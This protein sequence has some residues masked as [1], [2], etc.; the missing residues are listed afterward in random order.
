MPIPKDFDRNVFINCAFDAEYVPLFRAIV[1]TVQDAGFRARCAMEESDAGRV[2]LDKIL[3]IID[4]CRYGIHDISRTELD[5]VNALPRFN[6]PFE[7]GLDLASR[8]YGK[9]HHERKVYLVLDREKYRYQKYLSDI[10]GQDISA[11]ENSPAKVI[12]TVRNWLRTESHLTNIPGPK[13]ITQRHRRF[14]DELPEVCA[15]ARLD[16]DTMP[17]AELT[18]LIFVWCEA[19]PV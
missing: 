1:F 13:A 3:G 5:P 15:K 17:F 18:N 19:N 7:L 16:A 10:A 4:A 2:R 8:R 9:A 14:E 6:M 12:E 11:H